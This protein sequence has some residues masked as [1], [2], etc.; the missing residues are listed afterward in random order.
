MAIDP[1]VVGVTTDRT[2]EARTLNGNLRLLLLLLLLQLR[3]PDAVSVGIKC[4][5]MLAMSV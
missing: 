4:C 2:I 5:V 1:S 3:K